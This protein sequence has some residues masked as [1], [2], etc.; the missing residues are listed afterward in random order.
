MAPHST[1]SMKTHRRITAQTTDAVH[2]LR[3]RGEQDVQGRGRRQGLPLR[4]QRAC[5]VAP[6]L[7]R[8]PPRRLRGYVRMRVR[9]YACSWYRGWVDGTARPSVSLHR[10][11]D[12][13]LLA[14]PRSRG[15]TG[16]YTTITTS[17]PNSG[18]ARP[19]EPQGGVSQPSR[20]TCFSLV[21]GQFWCVISDRTAGAVAATVTA[22]AA[23]AGFASC[24]NNQEWERAPR[25]L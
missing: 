3:G 25:A 21:V 17:K 4:L 14:A 18:E 16:M 2:G 10:A 13:R 11:R 20:D 24:N 6:P 9:A 5:H 12:V 15:L 8:H 1:N 23:S 22:A 19:R 7:H